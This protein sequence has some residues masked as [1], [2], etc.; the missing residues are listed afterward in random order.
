MTRGSVAPPKAA[1]RSEAFV[2]NGTDFNGADLALD[3][4]DRTDRARRRQE[5]RQGAEYRP[6]PARIAFSSMAAAPFAN[7]HVHP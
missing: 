3:E 4:T 6:R 7:L 2:L 1:P 5:F